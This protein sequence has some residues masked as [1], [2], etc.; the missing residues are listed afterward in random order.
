MDKHLH[1]TVFK[2]KVTFILVKKE[3]NA[4]FKS[5]RL[6]LGIYYICQVILRSSVNID[7]ELSNQAVILKEWWWPFRHRVNIYRN[8][9][10]WRIR[11]LIDSK[12]GWPLSTERVTFSADLSRRVNIDSGIYF[13]SHRHK[14]RVI[15]TM[16]PLPHLYSFLPHPWRYAFKC[17]VIYISKNISNLFNVM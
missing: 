12:S 17:H 14:I 13:L 1:K 3:G 10:H 5:C 2:T 4:C 7:F 16:F 15:T 9:S 8:N 6:L 11:L